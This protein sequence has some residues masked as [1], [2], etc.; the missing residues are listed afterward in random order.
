MARSM[1]ER[2][3][4]GDDPVAARVGQLSADQVRRIAE[5]LWRRSTGRR[6]RVL[7]ALCG[8]GRL[9]AGGRPGGSALAEYRRRRRLEWGSYWC[10][11]AWRLGAVAVASGGAGLAVALAGQPGH[12]GLVALGAGMLAAYGLRF[13]VSPESAA[14][15]RGA[16]GERRTA[17]VLGRLERFGYTVLHDL[18]IPYSRANIDHL[19]VG[20]TGVWVVDSKTYSG[21]LTV[22]L[23]GTLWHGYRPLEP[24]LRRLWWQAG[25]VR[26]ALGGGEDA[27]VTPVLC[28]HGAQ[29]PW[30][31]PLVVAGVPVVAAGE[32]G[33][34]LRQA[35][36]L[37]PEQVAWLADHVQQA[38]HP[39]A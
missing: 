39:A 2:P 23:D 17:R 30:G 21:R 5:Q 34:V 7:A 13:R 6:W 24:T 14:W 38:F 22:G 36:E 11:L 8:R 12:A 10:S 32:L 9:R 16:A 19:V 26:A 25:I 1:G 4:S 15:Q 31:S 3:A 37:T 35:P 33:R 27:A 18:A 20:P 28:V 29:L